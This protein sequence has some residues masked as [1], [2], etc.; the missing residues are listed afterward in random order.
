VPTVVEAEAVLFA[1]TGSGVDEGHRRAVRDQTGRSA[2]GYGG[3]P[4]VP[5]APAREGVGRQWWDAAG[6]DDQSANA[7][8]P[9]GESLGDQAAVRDAEDVGCLQ[10]VEQS[11]Q[12]VDDEVGGVLVGAEAAGGAA[13]AAEV[14]EDE[15]V[16]RGQ[17]DQGFPQVG[18]IPAR[19]A[20]DHQQRIVSW[21]GR[22]RDEQ[23]DFGRYRHALLDQHVGESGSVS[24]QFA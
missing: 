5:F 13:A 17:L 22:A 19:T 1:A 21:T 7:A 3:E 9:E 6:G 18:V 23:L 16:S 15:L 4:S 2:G 20:V 12:V 10:V 8:G 14:R 11:D 24:Q